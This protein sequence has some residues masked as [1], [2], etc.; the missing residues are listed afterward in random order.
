MKA[1]YPVFLGVIQSFT[2]IFVLVFLFFL[3][4]LFKNCK[5]AAFPLVFPHQ[6]DLY[7]KTT[8]D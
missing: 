5:E 6:C 8:D 2:L 3:L 1:F 7:V 4:A